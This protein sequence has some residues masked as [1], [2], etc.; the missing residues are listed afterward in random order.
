[1]SNIRHTSQNSKQIQKINFVEQ[2]AVLGSFPKRTKEALIR[3][4][5]LIALHIPSENNPDSFYGFLLDIKHFN[6]ARIEACCNDYIK[7]ET[8]AQAKGYHYLKA[9]IRN[10]DKN[11]DAMISAQTAKYGRKFERR[12]L[13]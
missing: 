7:K 5:K 4:A 1:M 10:S 2:K 6:S 13:S 3:T 9:I 8:Y 11:S 12:V